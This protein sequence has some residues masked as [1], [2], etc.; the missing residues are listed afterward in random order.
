MTESTLGYIHST[1]SFGSVDGPGIRFV[2]FM[3]GCHMRCEFCHNPDTWKLK[4]GQ[5]RSVTSILQEAL[6]YRSYWGS[7]G[8][9]TVSGGEPLLQLDFLLALFKELKQAGIHTT[10]DTCGSPF[11]QKE[12][13]FS[14]FNELMNYTDLL[15]VDIKQINNEKH[16]KL[17]GFPNTNILKMLQY[18]SEIN[19]PVWIRHV[20][21]PERTDNDKDLL[22][23]HEFIQT[24]GNVDKVE[25]LPYHKLGVYKWEELGMNYPLAGIEPPSE[26]RVANARKILHTEDYKGFLKQHN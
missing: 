12:P 6:Q 25:V 20:L 5:S 16:R 18:L 17:T 15:L 13:F 11:T 19:K 24:L 14:K 9:I 21:I 4:A 8:G 22:A 1:E 23:L 10:L 2:I 3:Q 26:E 7:K